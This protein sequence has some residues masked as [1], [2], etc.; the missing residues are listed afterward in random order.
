MVA[1]KSDL[2]LYIWAA[3]TGNVRNIDKVFTVRFSKT[4]QEVQGVALYVGAPI[5]RTIVH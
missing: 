3:I 1:L 2:L 5:K 4:D